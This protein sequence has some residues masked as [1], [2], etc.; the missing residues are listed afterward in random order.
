MAI[1]LGTQ[2]FETAYTLKPKRFFRIIDKYLKKAAHLIL[3][4]VYVVNIIEKI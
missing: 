1:A 2:G 4:K 3:G